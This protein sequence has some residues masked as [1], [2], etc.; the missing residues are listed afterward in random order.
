MEDVTPI[1]APNQFLIDQLEIALAQ[2]KEGKLRSAV[3]VK[4]YYDGRIGTLWSIG[5]GTKIV[6]FL[7]EIE[8]FKQILIEWMRHY[9]DQ[10][11]ICGSSLNGVN[12]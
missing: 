1:L 4:M 11:G 3:V 2:A 12:D 8:Y 10:E 7:G 9:F 5:A 6:A